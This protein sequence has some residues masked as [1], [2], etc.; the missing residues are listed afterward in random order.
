MT[1]WEAIEEARKG[2]KI[3]FRSNSL[4]DAV[5]KD[6]RLVWAFNNSNVEIHQQ[7]LDGNWSVVEGP[8]KLYSFAE[9]YKMMKAGKW[10]IPVNL[11]NS[12]SWGWATRMRSNGQWEWRKDGTGI[13]RHRDGSFCQEQIDSQWQ[14]A[15]P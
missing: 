15:N 13:T 5:W 8:P 3:C 14:E 11:A 10:M 12:T 6:L 9:A 7:Y 4:W 2:K 1:F